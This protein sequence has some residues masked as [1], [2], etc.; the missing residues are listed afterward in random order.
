[1]AQGTN[2]ET[3]GE[4]SG[5]ENAHQFDDFEEQNGE[6]R[7]MLS[8]ENGTEEPGKRT[9]G[10]PSEVQVEIPM[11]IDVSRSRSP[12]VRAPSTEP[13][14]PAPSDGLRRASSKIA[15]LRAAF[16]RQNSASS[17]PVSPGPRSPASKGPDASKRRFDRS[18]A[19]GQDV[20]SSKMREQQEAEI[21]RL[22]HRL[23]EEAEL[24]QA[25]EDKCTALEEETEELRVRLSEKD[26]QWRKEVERRSK[27]LVREKERASGELTSIQRQLYEL[28]KSIAAATRQQSQ[29]AD[30]TFAQEMQ[31]LY[32]EIQNW[33][34]NNFRRVKLDKS[35]EEMCA[36][37]EAVAEPKHLEH[38]KPIFEN[39]DPATKLSALQAVTAYYLMEIFEEPLLFGMPLDEAWRRNVKG[40][41]ETLPSILSPAALNKWRAVTLDAIKQS[42]KI[43]ASVDSAS[44][45][46]SEMICITLNA[47]TEVEEGKAKVASLNAIIRRT[48]S[49]AHLFRVQRAQYDFILPPPGTAYSADAMEDS[50]LE[51]EDPVATTIRCATFP[52]VWKRGDEN[53]DNPE[54][55]NVVLKANVLCNP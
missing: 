34:V 42:T 19:R 23:D 29:T 54:L 24:R 49:L 52:A 17:L 13:A 44:Q 18:P 12:A 9:E 39:F 47:L 30:S 1:M 35:P 8:S 6:Q 26:A 27:E 2:P 45:S 40:A 37:L 11:T 28:K 31:H 46:M 4:I 15:N 5:I 3:Q 48:I 21:A 36:R 25:F 22:R 10:E 43:K 38:L 41:A 51:G 14:S 20:E 16:E 55:S 53:G 7:K 50:S 33:V 32:H